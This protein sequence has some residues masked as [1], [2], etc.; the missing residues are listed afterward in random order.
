MVLQISPAKKPERNETIRE[1][2]FSYL[3]DISEVIGVYYR[4]ERWSEKE[5]K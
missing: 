2:W 3:E 4:T 5:N 1:V